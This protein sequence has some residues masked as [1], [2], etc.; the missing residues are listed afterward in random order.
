[1]TQVPVARQ[2]DCDTRVRGHESAY[3]SEISSWPHDSIFI[4]F[5][6][7]KSTPPLYCYFTFITII[8]ASHAQPMFWTKFSYS[9]VRDSRCCHEIMSVRDLKSCLSQWCVVLI[10]KENPRSTGFLS[11]SELLSIPFDRLGIFR[12]KSGLWVSRWFL[13]LSCWY[14]DVCLSDNILVRQVSNTPFILNFVPLAS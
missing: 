13:I 6:F 1:V 4:F 12:R 9:V 14:W 11:F 7:L 10:N 3:L 2:D 5:F 8:F